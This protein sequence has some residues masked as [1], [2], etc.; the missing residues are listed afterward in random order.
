[1]SKR[2][3]LIVVDMQND[4]VTGALGTDEARAV[5]S[6]VVDKI[7]LYDRPENMIVFTR[8]THHD[9]YLETYEG[10]NLPVVHCVADTKGWEIVPEIEEVMPLD[11][12]I[13]DKHTFGS[14]A[15][16]EALMEHADENTIFEI[17]GLC[18]D[19]CVVTNALMIRAAFY[20][21]EVIVDK[22]CCAGVT[23][24]KHQAALATMDSCQVKIV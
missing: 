15:L 10:K 3:I 7:E 19:I 22:S 18:T 17:V 14:Y 24:E 13:I 9:D 4:F 5:V 21:N 1:M 2:R 6:R 8:D 11:S 12:P 20:E 23:P 16:V